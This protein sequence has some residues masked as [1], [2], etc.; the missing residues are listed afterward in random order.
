MNSLV[1]TSPA[2]TMEADRSAPTLADDGVRLVLDGSPV[3]TLVLIDRIDLLPKI[4][5]E[6]LIP[7]V[8][9]RELR[10]PAVPAKVAEWLDQPPLWL[11]FESGAP[12]TDLTR[13][14]RGAG[15]LAAVALCVG[16]TF[17]SDD[18]IARSRA[19]R[20]KIETTGTLGILR[21]LDAMGL[22]TYSDDVKAIREKT[23][24]RIPVGEGS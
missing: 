23:S 4:A 21:V 5:S 7:D 19:I 20:A 16:R 24:L 11:S 2:E 1:A 18:R 17:V 3:S 22:T 14:A 10:H 8:V 9:W 15:E 6:V 12:P 13:P